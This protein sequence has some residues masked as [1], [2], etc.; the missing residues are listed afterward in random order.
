MG[1]TQSR[2]VDDTLEVAVRGGKTVIPRIM[3]TAAQNN[4]FIDSIQLREPNLEDV[5][6]HYTGRNIRTEGGKE[7]HGIAAIHRRQIR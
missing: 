5:F 6:L 1:L 2:I 3:E 7:L 4:I